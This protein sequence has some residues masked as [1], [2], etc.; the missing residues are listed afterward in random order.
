MSSPRVICTPVLTNSGPGSS[1]PSPHE[2][3]KY[4][5]RPTS[6]PQTLGPSWLRQT[7]SI[8]PA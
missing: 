6:L 3:G 5:M 4:F 8:P 2:Q 1:C 7:Y